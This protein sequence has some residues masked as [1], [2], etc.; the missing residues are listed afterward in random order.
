M[1]NI[2]IS[3]IIPAYN[4]GKY[5]TECLESFK[6]FHVDESEIVVVND[7][8]TD[9]TRELV[10]KAALKDERIRLITVPNG[11]V[12]RARNS[13]LEVSRGRYIMF[14]DADD[15]LIESTFDDLISL[16]D[17][18]STEFAAFSRLIVGEG[19][20][21]RN[22]GFSFDKE[23]TS[24][25]SDIDRIMFAD[26][27]FNECWGK[28]YKREIIDRYDI[29][30]PNGV[31]IGEDLMFVM[32]YYSHCTEV[33]AC[34]KP[35]V[36]YRQHGESAM[37]RYS[38]SDRLK[39]TQDLFD[40]TKKYIPKDITSDFW[41]YNFKVLTNLCREYSRTVDVEAIKCIY[42]SDMTGEVINSLKR[43][44]IPKSRWHEYF[45]MRFKLNRISALYYRA[46]NS[47]L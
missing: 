40:F 10:E 21:S 2:S 23:S 24:D 15:Y 46:K 31:P 42:F 6:S 41:F 20:E 14:L 4:A 28:L 8:S 12:S 35:L 32:E 11:G 7:G 45:M 25:K 9:N 37:R 47:L 36:A 38:V 44:D 16:I 17:T 34:N 3:F 43:T 5:I 22:D 27:H 26:S 29:R 39:Y 30:F 1:S 18:G 13:G 33:F 19:K